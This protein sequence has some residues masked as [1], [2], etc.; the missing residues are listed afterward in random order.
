MSL[1]CSRGAPLGIHSQHTQT[2]LDKRQ[3]Y[4]EKSK[5]ATQLAASCGSA[6]SQARLASRASWLRLVN[7]LCS[8]YSSTC[9]VFAGAIMV[10]QASSLRKQIVASYTTAATAVANSV[11]T[12]GISEPTGR[13]AD[14]DLRLCTPTIARRAHVGHSL[15]S[16]YGENDDN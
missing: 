8:C 6:L 9:T 11:G 1:H 3:N 2:M 10:L 7:Q 16:L 14:A 15:N 13:A 4:Q 5:T 12:L